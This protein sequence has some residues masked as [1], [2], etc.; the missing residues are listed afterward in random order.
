MHRNRIN[1][2]KENKTISAAMSFIILF[3]IVSLFSDMTH[4]GASSI[5]GTYLSIIGASAGTIG[6]V[7]GL[8]EM[9]GYSMRYVFGRITDRTG[10]YWTMTI[11]GYLLD[12]IAVPALTF[13]GEDGWIFACI[14]LVIQKMGK[15]IKKPAKDTIMSFAA[16]QEGIGKS[17]GLQEMLDQIG[18]FLGPVMLYIVMLFKTSGTTFEI[19]SLCFATLAIP[20]AITIILL[21]ITKHKFPNPENFEPAAKEYIPFKIEKNFIKYIIGISF[22]AFGFMDYSIIIMHISRNFTSISGAF[23][24]GSSLINSGSIP[25]LYAGAMLVDAVAA[26]IFGHMYDKIGFRALVYST[27]VSATFP[28]FIFAFNSEEALIVGIILWGIGMGAQE[29]IL[30]AAVT[31]MVPKESRATGYGVFECSFGLFW[32]L[33]SWILGVLYDTNVIIMIILSVTAQILAI[34]FYL[35]VDKQK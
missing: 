21:I 12:L 16:T 4:E 35:S 27:I 8:G 30:K 26:I 13:V 7:S 33:G 15:A 1:K 18:A 9:I 5:R 6:F 31:S 28:I 10:K 23:A 2:I 11:A 19:Y 25:L 17:F 22:F 32:F 14:L 29:S 34:P 24:E 3:G 20:A